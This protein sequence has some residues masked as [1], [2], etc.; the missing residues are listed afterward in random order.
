MPFVG[1]LNDNGV[2][3]ATFSGNGVRALAASKGR[4]WITGLTVDNLG[5][6]VLVAQSNSRIVVARFTTTGDSDTTFSGDG[7]R[8]FTG[9]ASP[10]DL[11]PLVT[12]DSQG[13]LVVA[14][15]VER[16]REGNS[17]VVVRRLLPSG[18]LDSEWSGDGV[19]VVDNADADWVEGLTTDDRDRVLPRQ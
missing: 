9:G 19:K 2:L 11:F 13:R 16:H 8:Q 17:D 3:D 5:R 7:K 15:M 6:T 4:F 1:R 12:I 14:A 10:I 18:A